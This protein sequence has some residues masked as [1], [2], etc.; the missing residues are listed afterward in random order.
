[1][2][3]YV[4]AINQQNLA[5]T[6]ARFLG[7]FFVRDIHRWTFIDWTFR[8]LDFVRRTKIQFAQYGISYQNES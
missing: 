3:L 5:K 8:P 7:M 1:M 4:F 6:L 2:F